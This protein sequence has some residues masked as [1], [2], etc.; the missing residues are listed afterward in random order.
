MQ[1]TI[2]TVHLNCRDKVPLGFI[3]WQ[4]PFLMYEII[5]QNYDSISWDYTYLRLL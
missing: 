4:L 1:Q 5:Y 3:L 2:E